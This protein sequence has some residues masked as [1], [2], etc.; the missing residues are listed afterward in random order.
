MGE[1]EQILGIRVSEHLM[2]FLTS[3]HTLVNISKKLIYVT[4]SAGSLV[5]R[6]GLR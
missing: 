5:P 3:R 6:E 1:K 4:S 2:R